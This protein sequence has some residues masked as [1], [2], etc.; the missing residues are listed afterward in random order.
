M[1]KKDSKTSMINHLIQK[2][3]RRK[4]REKWCTKKHI[5]FSLIKLENF[6][7]SDLEILFSDAFKPIKSN[8]LNKILLNWVQ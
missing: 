8:I 4:F 5:L 7:T 2:I 3:V 1:R 6:S